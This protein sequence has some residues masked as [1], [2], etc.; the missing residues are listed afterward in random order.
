MTNFR[1]NEFLEVA[2]RGMGLLVNSNF[3][4]MALA[5]RE[6][7]KNSKSRMI[8]L[9]GQLAEG[10]RPEHYQFWGK[11]GIRAQLGDVQKR[12]LEMDFAIQ[13]DHRSMHILNAVSPAFTCSL[14]FS[15]YVCQQIQT[16]LH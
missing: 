15:E 4:F 2:V 3:D 12:K 11:P 1:W 13:G 14:P 8:S 9:A 10:V 16:F 6:L 5:V 7:G